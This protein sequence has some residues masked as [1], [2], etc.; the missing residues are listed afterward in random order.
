M[1]QMRGSVGIF[2][3]HYEN[4]PR[5]L[6]GGMNR[7]KETLTAVAGGAEAVSPTGTR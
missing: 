3:K 5:L 1:M 4:S 6:G 7:Q 2:N